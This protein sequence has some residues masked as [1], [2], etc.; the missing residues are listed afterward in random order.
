MATSNPQADIFTSLSLSLEEGENP[1]MSGPA[2]RKLH[3][4]KSRSRRVPVQNSLKVA[5]CRGLVECH[6]PHLDVVVVDLDTHLWLIAGAADT[7]ENREPL[8]H[9]RA[10]HNALL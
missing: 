10:R 6:P 4:P 5:F 9:A 7:R 3:A 2:S 1:S 8:S